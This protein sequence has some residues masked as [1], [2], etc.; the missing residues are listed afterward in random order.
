MVVGLDQERMIFQHVHQKILRSV[1]ADP[2]V[3]PGKP[4]HDPLVHVVRQCIWDAS[5]KHKHIPASKGIQPFI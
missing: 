1:H 3:C 5:G 4:F 2:Y